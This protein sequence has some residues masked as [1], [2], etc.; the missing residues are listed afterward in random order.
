LAEGS[1]ACEMQDRILISNKC[2][3]DFV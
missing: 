3:C 1:V 2:S